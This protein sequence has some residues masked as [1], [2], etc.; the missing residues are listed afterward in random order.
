MS[1]SFV[2]EYARL[3]T[4]VADRVDVVHAQEWPGGAAG[5]PAVDA[6][7]PQFDAV[8]DVLAASGGLRVGGAVG[9]VTRVPVFTVGGTTIPQRAEAM[10][11][12]VRRALGG[13]SATFGTGVV[14]GHVGYWGGLLAARLAD[15][16][17]AVF[18]TE[19]SSGLRTALAD[20]AGRDQYAEVLERAT[21]VFCVS[22]LLR[23]QILDALPGYA[24]TVEVLPNAVEFRAAPRRAEPPKR[25]DAWVFV[26]SLTANK[27]R[28]SSDW[29]GRSAWWRARNRRSRS[30]CTARGRSPNGSSSSRGTPVSGTGW[31][32][33]ASSGTVSCSPSCRGTTCCSRRVSSRPS[34]SPSSRRSRRG[35][36]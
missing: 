5:S 36:R 28:V 11:R 25:L 32:C 13:G 6:L 33:A 14:H 30:P 2:A 15:P 23:D 3:V 24:D 35:Y 7:R 29:F 9:A 18:A 4:R 20:P 10:V 27:T 8:L 19:H 21:K 16:S 34:T 17:S 22:G 1:G 12:D 31:T 26:G